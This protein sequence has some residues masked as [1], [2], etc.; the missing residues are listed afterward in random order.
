M[1][2]YHRPLAL[3]LCLAALTLGAMRPAVAQ[4]SSASATPTVGLEEVIVTAQKRAQNSQDVGIAISAVSGAELAELGAVS[5]SDITKS[6]P[7]VVL[8]QPNGPASFSLSIRG[9]TQNDFADHQESPAAIYVDDVYVSQMSGLA[10]SLYDMDRVEVLRGPQGT[11]FGRN[12]TGGLAN[13]VTRRPTADTGGYVNVTFGEYNLTRVEGAVNGAVVDGVNARLSFISNHYDP[14]FKNITGGAPNSENGNDWA[15]RGQLLFQNL[16]GGQ[17]LLNARASREDV[18]AGAWEQ[19]AS[20]FGT[21]GE[22]FLIGQGNQ[23]G[24][25]PG[26]NASGIPNAAN[27][28]TTDNRAGFAIIKSK[29]FTGKYTYD[30]SGIHFTAIG[31]YSTLNKNYQEDSDVSPYTIF[32]FFNGSDV[33]QSSLELRLNGEDQKLNWTAGA[34]GL[35]IDGNYYDGWEGPAF[36][37]AEEFNTAGNPNGYV[38]PTGVYSGYTA[39]DFTPGPWPYSQT[40]YPAGCGCPGFASPGS[41]AVA[42]PNGGLPATKSPYSLT[43]NSWAIFGQIEYR[44]TDLVGFTLGARFTSDKKDYNFSWY[45]YEYY[46]QSTDN[47][48][49]IL[50]RPQAVALNQDYAQDRSDNMWAGKAQVDFHVAPSQLLYVSYNRGVKGGGFTAPLFPPQIVNTSDLTFKP[51][52]LTSYELGYK[53]EFLDHTLRVN[54]AAYYYDYHDYQ[55]LI[56]TVSLNQLVKNANATHKG[57]ETEIDWA[58]VKAWRFGLGVAYL[59]A[60]VKNVP[61]LCCSYDANGVPSSIVGDYTPANAPKWTGNAMIRYTLALGG[62]DLSFQADGNYLSQFWFNLGDAPAVK[63]DAY[64]VYNA[65]INYVPSGGKFEIGASVEN[66][67]NEHYGTMGFDNTGVNGLAQRYPGMPRWFKAHVNF[68]F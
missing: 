64:G 25:C 11:L 37:G 13:F 16:G 58:P 31:D 34:Y 21:N 48:V 29:G 14:L 4:Q 52:E 47:K 23:W 17:L 65:R 12:A 15:V 56:Y 68:H 46:P 24:T 1:N 32:Q 63:Q 51:E 6:V 44:L 19:Y 38:S 39:Y 28:T 45:P 18:H 54:S 26:C 36:F 42:D 27:F 55:A 33:N 3:I 66:I 30:F 9:V 8:T 59:D 5:A 10:F 67:A 62:A 41:L 2:N 20:Y 40:P 43:T 60:V 49:T 22:N 35:H 61:G 7:A 57:V 53:S 50:T